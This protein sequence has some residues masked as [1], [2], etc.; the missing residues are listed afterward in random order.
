M[1]IKKPRYHA[2]QRI[3]LLIGI[4]LLEAAGHMAAAA[5]INSRG[6]LPKTIRG[7]LDERRFAQAQDLD[8]GRFSLPVNKRIALSDLDAA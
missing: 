5:L 8:I 2:K 1:A 7:S 3:L 4:A 6:N